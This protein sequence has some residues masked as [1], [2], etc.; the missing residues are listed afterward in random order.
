MDGAHVLLLAEDS[1]RFSG[2]RVEVIQ[3]P[4]DDYARNRDIEPHRQGPPGDPLVTI[5][6][7]VESED[8]GDPDRGP[9][10]RTGGPLRRPRS[11]SDH[12][13]AQPGD[14]SRVGAVEVA[15][16]VASLVDQRELVAVQ[17]ATAWP[18]VDRVILFNP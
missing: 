17:N 6:V 8:Q 1:T 15:T 2:R 9:G 16:D 5:V 7:G 11:E 18:G 3:H 12:G 4:I 10:R 13:I 14:L